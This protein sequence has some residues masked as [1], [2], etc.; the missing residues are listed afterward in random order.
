MAAPA[1][2]YYLNGK[3]LYL[4]FGVVL[5]KGSTNDFL[6]FPD[7]KDSIEHDWQ[8]SNGIDVDLSRVFLKSKDVELKCILF[9]NSFADYWSK[10][11]HFFA[12]LTAPGLKRFQISEFERSFFIYYKSSSSPNRYTRLQDASKIVFEFNIVVTEQEPIVTKDVFLVTE[13]GRF[14]IT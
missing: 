14:I 10:Y 6:K 13:D 9:G 3:D 4:I 12:E 11:D 7:R 8:D 5:Q 2:Q 1:G